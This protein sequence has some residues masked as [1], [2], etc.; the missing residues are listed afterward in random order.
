[1]RWTAQHTITLAAPEDHSGDGD[2]IVAVEYTDRS[3]NAAVYTGQ[4]GTHRYTSKQLTIDTTSPVITVQG[5]K[6]ESANNDEVIG[7][8]IT[9]DDTNLDAS[10][11]EPKLTA[12]YRNDDGGFK[13]ELIDFG[14]ETILEVGKTHSLTVENLD[15][16]AIYTLTATIKDMSGNMSSAIIIEDSEE[17]EIENI[18]FSVNREGS[19]FLPDENTLNLINAYFV[20]EVANNI[21]V[22]EIN[23]DPLNEY[24]VEMNKSKLTEGTG[25]KVNT[26]ADSGTWS[27]YRYTVES[28]LFDDENQYGLVISST[29][30]TGTKAY[31][32]LK[33]V[34]IGFV[35]DQTAPTVEKSGV[36][37]NARY[38]TE[39]QL[40]TLIPKDEGGKLHSIRVHLVDGSENEISEVI[41]LE[42]DSL[43]DVI[44]NNNGEVTFEILQGFNQNVRIVCIDEAGN[45]YEEIFKG[46][47]VSTNM[48]I[49]FFANKPLFI[50]SI[51][52]VFVIAGGLTAF[53]IIR[54]R[55]IAVKKEKV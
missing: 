31:S 4:S 16:D 54:R 36:D 1:M 41:N 22:D 37:N 43:F 12:L 48:F 34:E 5:I 18:V 50:G 29:D 46:I 44:D 24:T 53:L 25:F 21:V 27:R 42:R 49:L 39:S 51:I 9:A 23:V 52:G 3:K 32:D 38:Q 40:V 47:T 20:Q 6:H 14:K 35:V 45:E 55:R 2:Y 26:T 10:A 8:T 33:Q 30:K 28:S 19:T 17:K 13:T 11:F 7:F 15:R